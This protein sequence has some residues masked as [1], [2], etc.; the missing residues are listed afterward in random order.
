MSRR[1]RTPFRLISR[2]DLTVLVERLSSP[3]KMETEIFFICWHQ[4]EMSRKRIG[5]VEVRTN[6]LLAAVSGN[7]KSRK[8]L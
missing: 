8:L 1:A 2:T 5:V 7:S 4:N 3:T 6:S